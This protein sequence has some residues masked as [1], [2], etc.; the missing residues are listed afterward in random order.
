VSSSQRPRIDLDG[1]ALIDPDRPGTNVIGVFRHRTTDGLVI[2]MPESGEIVVP[3]TAVKA[4][5]LDLVSGGLR[6]EL[7]PR[8][9]AEET[10]LRGAKTLTGR[11]LDRFTMRR[12]G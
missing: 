9:T 7:E 4:A 1:V 2:L 8:Y 5:S 10:W 11:W 6:I 12:S 3:W